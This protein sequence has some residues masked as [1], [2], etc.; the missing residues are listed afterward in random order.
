M[1]QFIYDSSIFCS[2][3]SIQA[4]FIHVL[5]FYDANMK[6]FVEL[7]TTIDANCLFSLSLPKFISVSML[8]AKIFQKKI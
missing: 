5:H 7:V 6:L 1:L 8:S 3:L 4:V 2:M